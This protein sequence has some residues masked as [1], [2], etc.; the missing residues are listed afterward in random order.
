MVSVNALNAVFDIDRVYGAFVYDSDGRRVAA[1]GEIFP[2]RRDSLKPC[3]WLPRESRWGATRNLPARKFFSYFVPL[4]ATTGQIDGLLQVV[5]R[6]SDMI[7]VAG[8]DSPVWLVE[9]DCGG[10]LMIWC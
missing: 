3:R 8:P 9:L 5:R 10:G 4:V 1:V 6:K 7:R 2:G